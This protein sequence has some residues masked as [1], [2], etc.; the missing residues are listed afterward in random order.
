MVFRGVGILAVLIQLSC[1]L[2]IHRFDAHPLGQIGNSR[3]NVCR[4]RGQ[5][6]LQVAGII[7]DTHRLGD[8][9]N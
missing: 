3:G 9:R 7:Q 1:A 6:N 4:F 8:V 2:C 5:L